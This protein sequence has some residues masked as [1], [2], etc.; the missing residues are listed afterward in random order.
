MCV[1]VCLCVVLFLSDFCGVVRFLFMFSS[2]GSM[3]LLRSNYLVSLACLCVFVLF[4][5]VICVCLFL[6]RCATGLF[7]CVTVSSLLISLDW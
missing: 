6:C 7:D 1:C 2:V 3:S 5:Y 4:V